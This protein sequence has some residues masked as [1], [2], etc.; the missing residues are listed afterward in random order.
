MRVRFAGVGRLRPKKHPLNVAMGERSLADR[1]RPGRRINYR[2]SKIASA[3]STL[4][5]PKRNTLG[6]RICIAVDR[7][8]A[9]PVSDDRITHHYHGTERLIAAC[10]GLLLQ[11]CG[12]R[13]KQLLLSVKCG[14]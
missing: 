8:A 11:A 10:D 12:L 14:G 9:R 5:I 2:A 13:N 1:A 3:Q 6:M 7:H 4:G